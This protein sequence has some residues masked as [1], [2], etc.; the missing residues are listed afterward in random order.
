M[1]VREVRGTFL[2]GLRLRH[3]LGKEGGKNILVRGMSMCKGHEEGEAQGTG[4]AWY[5]WS[6]EEESMVGEA[7]E[8]G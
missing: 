4:G 1:A 3:C 7:G 8:V 6:R 5:S 2:L